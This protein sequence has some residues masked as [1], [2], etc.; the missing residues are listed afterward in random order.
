MGMWWYV[1]PHPSARSHDVARRPPLLQAVV[2]DVPG[3]GAVAYAQQHNLP[4]FTYPASKKSNNEGLTVE[5]LVQL[6]HGQLQ[7]DLV[8]LAGYLKV[9]QRHL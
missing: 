8:L 6:L 9:S 4:T 5:E 3:C 1:P 7:V 2:S